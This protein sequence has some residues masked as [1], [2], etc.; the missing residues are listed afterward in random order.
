MSNRFLIRVFPWLLAAALVGA[1]YFALDRKM[2]KELKE[3]TLSIRQ[4]SVEDLIMNLGQLELMHYNFKDV[5]FYG[6]IKGYLENDYDFPDDEPIV[7]VQGVAY[8]GI[9]FDKVDEDDFQFSNDSTLML[10]VPYPS[11][12]SYSLSDNIII[13]K[14]DQ[15]KRDEILNALRKM[16]DSHDEDAIQPLELEI[17]KDRIRMILEPVLEKLTNEDIMI[18]FVRKDYRSLRNSFINSDS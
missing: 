16:V 7:V 13:L 10:V 3:A 1:I 8:A 5:I 11:Q 14:K 2:E 4:K 17:D 15:M 6:S 18:N 12:F 9:D